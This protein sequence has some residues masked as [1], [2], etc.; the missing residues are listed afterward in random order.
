[1][2]A[3]RFSYQQAA[4]TILTGILGHFQEILF[5]TY[6]EDLVRYL[7]L[8]FVLFLLY[9]KILLLFVSTQYFDCSLMRLSSI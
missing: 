3:E 7:V 1:M 4:T 8:N 5:L 6:L 9:E 2:I